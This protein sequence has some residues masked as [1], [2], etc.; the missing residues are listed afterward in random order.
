MITMKNNKIK[1]GYPIIVVFYIMFAHCTSYDEYKKFM[2]DGE[3]IY[4][5]KADSLKTYPG[6]NRMLLEWALVDPKVTSCI[7]TY[8]QAGIQG[9]ITVPLQDRSDYVNDTIRLIIPDLEETTYRFKIVSYDD[10]GHASLTVEAEAFVYGEMYERSLLNRIVKNVSADEAWRTILEWYEGDDNEIGIHLNYTDVNGGNH[11]MIVAQSETSTILQDD[12]NMGAQ[13]SYYTMY[14]PV[15]S[16]IDTFYAPVID[17]HLPKFERQLDR[18]K[19]NEM[20]LPGDMPSDPG[21]PMPCLWDGKIE[22]PGYH[23][24]GPPYDQLPA[25]FTFDL[26]VEQGVKLSRYTFWQRG[27]GFFYVSGNI[28]KFQIW[29]SMDPNPDGSWD[30]TW[31]LL[32]DEEVVKPSGL[33]Y[34]QISDADIQAATNGEE[35]LFPDD[36]PLVRYIRIKVEDIWDNWETYPYFCLLQVAF[37]ETR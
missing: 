35:Y 26:G 11:S 10:F 33:P 9:S 25:W 4:P 37:W 22:I 15:P 23:S 19:F 8:E 29:G 32:L 28:R 6:R 1:I 21:W 14:K 7:V 24:F 16:A 20:F 13:L 18:L 31:I 17:Y 36:V 27:G 3:I 2:P 5:Q 34:G 12:I 30:D